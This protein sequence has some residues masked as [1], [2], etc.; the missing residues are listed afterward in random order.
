MGQGPQKP[1]HRGNFFMTPRRVIASAAWRHLS[2]RA[3][4][5]LQVLQSRHDGFNNGAIGLSV[6]DLGG[7]LG[8]QNHAANSRALAELIEKG[9]VE[10]TGDFD[11]AQ[12]R[13]REFTLTFIPTGRGKEPK[14]PASHDYETWRPGTRDQRKFGPAETATQNRFADAAAATSV[15]VSAA[16]I[17]TGATEKRGFASP[18]PV[19]NT[20][21]HIGNHLSDRPGLPETL[22]SSTR[23]PG[24]QTDTLLELAQLRAWVIAVTIRTDATART[25]ARDADVPEPALSRLKNHGKLPD[26]YRARL[27]AACGRRLPYNIHRADAA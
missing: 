6:R 4:S 17:A 13:S 27:Q 11:R 14:Q 23:N 21:A 18:P 7:A 25:L 24:G 12:S 5:A 9:F 15:K 3:R 1:D 20:A 19:A 26:K 22:K 8:N 16:D 2:D 10:L